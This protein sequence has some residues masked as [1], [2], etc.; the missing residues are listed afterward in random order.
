MEILRDVRCP[1]CGGQ[2]VENAKAYGCENWRDSDGGCKATIW[3]KTW[4]HDVT[5]DEA[6]VMFQ[7]GEI[8][9]IE[10]TLK[11]GMKKRAKMKYDAS[12]NKCVLDF[13]DDK[14]AVQPR[15]TYG[16]SISKAQEILSHGLHPIQ[17]TGQIPTLCRR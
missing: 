14:K 13:V 3:K 11:S 2:I 12:M 6:A 7:G 17:M 8:G 4:G 10:V 1:K 16:R 9:P 15:F 5:E